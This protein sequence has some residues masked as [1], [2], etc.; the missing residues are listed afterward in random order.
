MIV[1]ND[2][3]T[4]Q[5]G[6][7]AGERVFG[8]AFNKKM[9]DLMSTNL[10]SDRIGSTVRETCSNAW[11]AHTA[12]KNSAPF[13]VTLPTNLEPHFI[14]ED[15]GTGMPDETAQDLYST[16]GLSTK[17]QS[18]D[19]IGAFGLGS[20]VP[21]TVTDSFSVENTHN[22]K[23]YFYLCFKNEQGFPSILKTGEVDT[24]R[25]N[26]VKVVIPVA[27]AKYNLFIEAMKRQLIM[28]EPKPVI[29]NAGAFTF[30]EPKRIHELKEG[31]IIENA[32][33]FNL[34]PRMV[35]AKMGIVLYP[36]DMEQIGVDRYHRYH[37]KFAQ[38]SATV[39][40]FDI[41]DLD[42]VPS[43]EGLT[44]DQSGK[45]P[46]NIRKK[47]YAYKDEL[48]EVIKKRILAEKHTYTAWQLAVQSSAGIGIDFKKK[49]FVVNGYTIGERIDDFPSFKWIRHEPEVKDDKG[50][51]QMK[52]R[53]TTFTNQVYQFD[54]RTSSW[55]KSNSWSK[56]Q[57]IG[58]LKFE[59]VE[60]LVNGT[61]KFVLMNEVDPKRRT[62]RQAHFLETNAGDVRF[63]HRHVQ[64]P[65]D[66]TDWSE[67]CKKFD[68]FYPGLSDKFVKFSDV[69][70][71]V[72]A[73]DKLDAT[74]FKGVTI[75]EP[76]RS[77]KD[78]SLDIEFD[79]DNMFYIS[80]ERQA[81]VKYPSLDIKLFKELCDFTQFSC[82]LVRKGGVKSVAVLED[83]GI[84]EFTDF[85]ANKLSGFPLRDK[86]KK[87]A[88]A[89][90]IKENQLVHMTDNMWNVY[91][92]IRISFNAVG[93]KYYN[94]IREVKGISDGHQTL[95]EHEG[96][97]E[98]LRDK[99][100]I[101][102][103]FKESDWVKDLGS[104]LHLEFAAAHAA[105]Y[106]QYPLLD[107]TCRNIGW[108]YTNIETPKKYLTDMNAL[109]EY[110]RKE[111]LESLAAQAQS[112]IVADVL[113]SIPLDTIEMDKV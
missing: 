22:G 17:E 32:Y 71:P 57:E 82:I 75:K 111:A 79:E 30:N 4:I 37:E 25:G 113:E 104:T 53:N 34:Q 2:V 13:H 49:G 99:G 68:D 5:R 35:Y 31:F 55:R 64:N 94:L 45:T 16:L 7:I 21:F 51:V 48:I 36:I 15:F 89:L 42:P 63:I 81:L 23:T 88:D 39:L 19:M 62:V 110:R 44:Y 84:L 6:G 65:G 87:R 74:T 18:N 101:D 70:A 26:G 8:F 56:D 105:F 3:N 112:I 93:Q 12:A 95:T 66:V 96:L 59:L 92:K 72:K 90:T 33:D 102:T 80:A 43:R 103:L 69:K 97:V 107:M 86:F 76:G 91:E 11:D 108:P 41:G 100:M 61:I 20:K 73:R 29:T 28:M 77:M 78:L 54:H 109:A 83:N 50:V 58:E 67:F 106:G 52:E 9:Y 27:G 98:F 14:V 46:E 1:Q 47:Y 10:Y 60:A 85:V 24:D 38:N 40:N